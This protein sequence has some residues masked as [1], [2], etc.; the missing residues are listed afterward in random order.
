MEII[1]L[2]SAFPKGHSILNNLLKCFEISRVVH[3]QQVGPLNHFQQ[4]GRIWESVAT[5]CSDKRMRL[6]ANTVLTASI[7][8]V[9][10]ERNGK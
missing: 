2:T 3:L 7:I 6:Q 1:Y 8:I 10:V 5:A 9:V 4:L